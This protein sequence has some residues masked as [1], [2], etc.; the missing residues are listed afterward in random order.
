MGSMGTNQNRDLIHNIKL[1]SV[2]PSKVSGEN[3]VHELTAMDKAMKLHYIR[4]LYIFKKEAVQGL[5]INEIKKS[6]FMCLDL[7]YPVS[8]RIRRR[9]VG[10]G[11]LV[12]KCNDG[13]VRTVEADC[14]ITVDEW[15]LMAK[16]DQLINDQLGYRQ[17]LGPD[18]GFS[19]LVYIQFTWFK[20]GGLSIGL[21][22]AHILG[23]LFSAS[24]FI[25]VWATLVAG[26]FHPPKISPSPVNPIVGETSHISFKTITSV[27]DYWL[28]PTNSEMGT[29]TFHF[30]P[31]Q[32]A[33][34]QHL[35]LDKLRPFHVLAA[36]MWK[37]LS[38]LRN[39]NDHK[40]LI[41]SH[42]KYFGRGENELPSNTHVRI[43]TVE[44]DFSIAKCDL[45]RLAN[46][47]CKEVI[48]ESGTIYNNIGGEDSDFVVYGGSY[49]TFVDAEDI[50]LYGLQMNEEKS[51]FTNYMVAGIGDCGAVLVLPS[52]FEEDGFYGRTVTVTLPI[53][54]IK[55]LKIEVKNEMEVFSS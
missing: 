33:G 4:G 28:V 16:D 36:F 38:K 18:L 55:E 32:I 27:G 7:Y 2:V 43:G 13:G 52:G 11:G 14:R 45:E 37:H 6:L 9:D 44:A 31:K 10:E 17:V 30:T 29:H 50:D 53:N 19:P 15:L 8:G 51:V 24:E 46:L 1:S 12:I 39:D 49:L 23:D 47:I 54:E 25:N 20:C 40:I 48:D 3:K 22:W 35:V 21:S 34:L 26:Q 5:D 42:E 41:V